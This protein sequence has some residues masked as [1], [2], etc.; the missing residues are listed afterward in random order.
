[1]ANNRKALAELGRQN[2]SEAQ[3][4]ELGQQTLK[5]KIAE[6]LRSSG[7]SEATGFEVTLTNGETFKI[8]SAQ[9]PRINTPA[10]EV[11]SVRP[12]QS[13][14]GGLVLADLA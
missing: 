1:M 9:N 14:R 7:I 6:L 12:V 2:L 13:A 5:N 11:A 4:V 3:A 8:A 10:A